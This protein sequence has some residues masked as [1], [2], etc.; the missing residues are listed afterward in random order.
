MVASIQSGLAR[1]SHVE[2]DLVTFLYRPQSP[3]FVSVDLNSQNLDAGTAVSFRAVWYK[4][5][6]G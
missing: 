4:A 3:P 5:N 1:G 6:I 2:G